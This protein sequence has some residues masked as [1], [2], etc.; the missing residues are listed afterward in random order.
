M[1][2]HIL[3]INKDNADGEII[4]HIEECGKIKSSKDGNDK[5]GLV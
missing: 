1:D 5:E 3:Q 4:N 2:F